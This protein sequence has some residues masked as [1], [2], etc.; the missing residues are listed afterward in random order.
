MLVALVAGGAA[1]L[2]RLVLAVENYRPPLDQPVPNGPAAQP[3]VPQVV[4]VIIE[5]LT[6]E[7]AGDM[8]SL[9]A[10]TQDQPSEPPAEAR[11][12]NATYAVAQ[13]V[14][15]TRALPAW[16]ALVTG[17]GP[18]LSGAPL[19]H[20]SPE[21]IE[22]LPGD[23]LF[24]L[25]RSAGLLT[26]F[27]GHESWA[28]LVGPSNLDYSAITSHKG[29]KADAETADAALQFL[30]QRPNL[31]VIHLG[32]L[33]EAGHAQGAESAAYAQALQEIDRHLKSL[34]SRLDLR[35]AVLVVT[36]THGHLARGGH[37]GDE[38]QVVRIP[39]VLA[40]Q[41]ITSDKP[42]ETGKSRQIEAR[43]I[44]VAPTV[45]ALLGIPIPGRNQGDVLTGRLQLGPQ[46]RAELALVLAE[47]RIELARTYLTKVLDRPL[48]DTAEGDRQVAQ[49]SIEV[50][51]YESA[52]TLAELASVQTA[53]ETREAR[54]EAIE[55]HRQR[56]LPLAV[57]A[58][59]V[60]A[61]LLRRGRLRLFRFHLLAALLTIG[62]FHLL[63][64]NLAGRY[65]PSLL[66]GRQ[67]LVQ[68]GRWAVLT[69]L[70]GLLVVGW[71]VWRSREPFAD[72][73]VRAVYG[74]GLVTAYLLLLGLT[75]LLQQHDP[76][77][78][79]YLPPP[80]PVFLIFLLGLELVVALT[81][82]L[83]LAWPAA[84]LFRLL[85]HLL[86]RGRASTLRPT[87]PLGG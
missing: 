52:L 80:Q 75:V 64:L 44:D 15:P 71:A 10:L 74:Y 67:D 38:P 83:V 68:W 31:L 35:H 5:G 25:A 62:L 22:P 29:A 40:G 63:F 3:L 49:S 84:L 28:K 30:S 46:A 20:E 65:S 79:W 70:P 77:L 56:L 78:G 48:S 33:D 19:V 11:R 32:Q 47:Q 2:R 41:F 36:S 57:A 82:L 8:R 55:A 66:S 1:G 45:A 14:V 54:R 13:A 73:Y 85:R 27:A 39:L 86:A 37:G 18:E 69:T 6:E 59:V 58:F 4:M 16:A 81:A 43:Q 34:L 12:A 23:N 51:N 61:Y 87:L 72:R 26:A 24:S 50:G 9:S 60:P 7:G 76:R 17:A 53:E 21:R 42:G